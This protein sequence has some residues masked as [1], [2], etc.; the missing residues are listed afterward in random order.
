MSRPSKTLLF[1]SSADLVRADLVGERLQVERQARPEGLYDLG[2][3]VEGA[4]HLGGRPARKVWVLSSDLWTQTVDL[5]AVGTRNLEGEELATALKFE[6]EGLSGLSPLESELGYVALAP[7]ADARPFWVTQLSRAE[8]SE[9][10]GIVSDAGATLA[11]IAH[12]AGLP[13][14]LNGSAPGE[15]WR[16]TELWP[17]MRF[18]LASEGEAFEVVAEPADDEGLYLAADEDSHHLLVAPD[19]DLEA[20]E[21]RHPTYLREGSAFNRWLTCWGE[22]LEQRGPVP[23]VAPP[24]QPLSLGIQAAL[25][26]FLLA[27]V[28]ALCFLHYRSVTAQAEVLQTELDRVASSVKKAQGVERS[29]TR[30]KREVTD[31]ERSLKAGDTILRAQRERAPHL[32]AA[33]AEAPEGLVI[34][35][36]EDRGQEIVVRGLVPD[37]RL[38][39]QLAA[40]LAQRLADLEWRVDPPR[41]TVVS[42]SRSP[43]WSFELRI[44]DPH[45][46]APSAP[47]PSKRRRRGRR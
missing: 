38:P 9:V 5:P 45:K 15:P 12:P 34:Q 47:A 37:P 28:G 10:E 7:R 19:L 31:L 18:D 20:R 21:D 27:L 39:N 36:I 8:L 14:S 25:T 24:P 29:L 2:L 16:R 32:L 41:S 1:I 42:G 46:G 13:G 40:D 26:L 22:A 11:G 44:H 30:L 43:V 17:G 3:L 35:T 6:T 4:L 33:L 23:C